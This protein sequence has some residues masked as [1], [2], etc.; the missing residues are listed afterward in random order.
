MAGVLSVRVTS[1]ERKR[2]LQLKTERGCNNVS[3]LIRLMLGFPRSPGMEIL[4]GAD[5]IDSVGSLVKVVLT[6]IDRVEMTNTVVYQLAQQAG[7]RQ[8]RHRPVE[9]LVAPRDEPVP[10]RNGHHHPALPEGFARG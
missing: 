10:T 5:D 3:D 2:L 8:V 7:L 1:Q 9:D 6:M 4:D